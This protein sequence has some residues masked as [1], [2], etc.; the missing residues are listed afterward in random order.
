[1]FGYSGS[2][3]NKAATH[4]YWRTVFIGRLTF[5]PSAKTVAHHSDGKF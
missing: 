4:I 1:M 5:Y 3:L 2:A